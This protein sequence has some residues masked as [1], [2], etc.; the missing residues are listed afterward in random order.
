MRVLV[1]NAGSSSLKLV[2]LADGSDDPVDAEAVAGWDGHDVAPIAA[3]LDRAGPVDAVGHR[4][5]HGGPELQAPVVV[6]DT[7]RDRIAA[8]VSLAPLHQP[9]SVAGIDAARTA[10]PDLPHVAC[11]D[12]GYHATIPEAAS[13]YALPAAW[14]LSLIHI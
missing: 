6:D 1:V 2:V 13:T 10:V 8:L 3:L 5:V 14:R 4:V 11:F 12:T 7:V 9:R